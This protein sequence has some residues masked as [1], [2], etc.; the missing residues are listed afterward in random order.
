M[1]VINFL[2]FVYLLF[3]TGCI[4]SSTKNQVKPTTTSEKRA[5]EKP[6]KNNNNIKNVTT[7]DQLITVLQSNN[8]KS[9]LFFFMNGCGWCDMMKPEIEKMASKYSQ[10]TFYKINGPQLKAHKY[11]ND[12]MNIK[13]QGYPFFL[14]MNNGKVEKEKTGGMAA[15]TFEK[16]I[17][18]IA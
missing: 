1:K 8:S 18:Q 7:E 11:L 6:V 13:V 2:S 15:D 5:P 16:L 17:Q 14:F 12:N 9:V 10:V 4:G 3:I